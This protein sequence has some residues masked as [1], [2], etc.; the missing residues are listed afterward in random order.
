MA[1]TVFV[2]GGSGFI[3]GKLVE[4]LVRE[5]TVRALARSESSARRVEELGAEAVRGELGDRASLAAGAAD[6]EATVHLAAHLG[7]WGPW[8][9]FEP[10]P[11]SVTPRSSPASRASRSFGTQPERRT[12]SYPPIARESAS[13]SAAT[14]AVAL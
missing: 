4:R 13:S 9:E 8:E 3:G 12:C 2:T 11:S 14:G 10:E 5:G 6:A 7:E 1:K